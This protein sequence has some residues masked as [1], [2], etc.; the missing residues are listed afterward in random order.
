[1]ATAAKEKSATGKSKSWLVLAIVA[2]LA[3]AGGAALPQILLGLGPGKETGKL[4]AKHGKMTKPAFVSFGDVVVNLND[5]RLN[6][7][8]RIKIIL[9]MDH[10]E[11]KII[12]E[13]VGQQKAILK[14]WLITYLRDRSLDEVKGAAGAN[15]LRREIQDRFNTLLFTDGTDRI[16]DVLFEEF[17]IQ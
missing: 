5:G 13:L 15:R 14:N 3:T 2:A 1:M 9:V 8:L 11:E 10:A 12:T 4:D 6:R 17:V 16:Q 7:Y